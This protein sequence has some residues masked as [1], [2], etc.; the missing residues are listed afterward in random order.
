MLQPGF[1]K[2][3][4]RF[5]AYGAP[6][7][8]LIFAALLILHRGDRTTDPVDGHSPTS[9][10]SSRVDHKIP[11]GAESATTSFFPS[12]VHNPVI[13]DRPS[14][15][16]NRL[17]SREDKDV[18]FAGNR[19]ISTARLEELVWS[20]KDVSPD[21]FSKELTRKIKD[22]YLESGFLR[23]TATLETDPNDPAKILISIDEGKQ[24]MWGGVEI[25]SELLPRECEI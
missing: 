6:S 4:K 2:Y 18:R 14:P 21:E 1:S 8:F 11:S 23:A 5:G 9:P 16:P 25:T 7:V 24:Y 19:G 15:I 12:T 3:L 20:L 13:G 10:V 17:S 22:I